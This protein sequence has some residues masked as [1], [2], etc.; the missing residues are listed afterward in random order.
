M[1]DVNIEP[2][3]RVDTSAFPMAQPI[4]DLESKDPL[5]DIPSFEHVATADFKAVACNPSTTIAAAA[6]RFYF[7]RNIIFLNSFMFLLV[8]TVPTPRKRGRPRKV[9][10][11]VREE[12]KDP[13]K[14]EEPPP[15]VVESTRPKRSCRGPSVR[16][17]LGIKPRKSR[18][19]GRGR[20]GKRAVETRA[21]VM[22]AGKVSKKSR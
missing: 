9:P 17:T 11:Q 22:K 4:V 6:G 18:G 13:P 8:V 12:F 19:P 10:L 20:G 5:G 16:A 7:G 2:I 3:E 1:D 21:T 15:V 14:E